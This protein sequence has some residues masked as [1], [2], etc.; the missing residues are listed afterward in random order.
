[1]SNASTR[2]PIRVCLG[3]P[4]FAAAKYLERLASLD[5]VEASVLPVNPGADWAVEPAGH[6]YAEPPPWADSV[7]AEREAILAEAHVLTT[8]HAPDRLAERAPN[9]RWIQGAGAGVEQFSTAGVAQDRVVLT[10]CSGVSAGSMS[11]WVIGRLLQVWKRFREADEFQQGH[12]FERSYGRT[13]AGSTIGIVGLGGIGKAVAVRARALGCRTLGLKRSAKPGDS[14]EDVDELFSTDRLHELL[15]Q[16]DAVIVSAPATAETHHMF[17]ASAL[18]AMPRHAVLVNV[19]RGTLV[20]QTELAR[21]MQSDDP[22]AA[23]VLDVFD[24][25]PLEASSPLWD[26]PN[27]YVSAHSSVSVDRYMDDVFELFCDNL[28]RFLRG[29]P[30]RNVIDMKSLGFE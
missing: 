17:D 5:G 12:R 16:S 27:V 24:P 23:A 6:P 28:E 3:F 2:D 11:E 4:P 22:L 10:N 7:A 19:A 29:D 1:M 30:L 25:E 18:A 26:I 8:L 14:S 15:A 20:D 13:F 9:L 21:V